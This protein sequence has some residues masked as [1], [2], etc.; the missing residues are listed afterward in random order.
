MLETL[1]AVVDIEQPIELPKVEGEAH[2][3]WVKAKSDFIAQHCHG[4]EPDE[5]MTTIM[6]ASIGAEP[7]FTD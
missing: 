3:R 6:I 4:Q 2:N 7:A 5:A 1:I